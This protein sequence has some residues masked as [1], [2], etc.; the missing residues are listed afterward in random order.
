THS[1]TIELSG[2]VPSEV[3]VGADI[4]LK[5]K[6]SCPAGCDLRGMP[7]KVTAPDGVAV[8][9]EIATCDAGINE[10]ADVTLKAPQQVGEHVLSVVFAPHEA[11]GVLHEAKALPV[12]VRTRPHATSLAVWA[13]PSP[14]V[15]GERFGIKVGAKSAA[16]CKL[17]A[18]EIEVRDQT[19][20]IIA[21]ANLG[22]T[23]WPETSALFWTDVELLAP[24]EEGIFSWSVKFAAA[25]V[26]MPHEGASSNFSVVVVKP[27]QHRL[28]VNVIEKETAA[29]VENVQVRLG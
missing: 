28:T 20:A 25:E 26:E 22:E 15:M 16:G 1:T 18:K 7:V 2:A 17:D 10:T 29:P 9:S 14:V 12:S 24:A 13:V 8:A 21:R 4:I 5:V 6:V 23:P 19:G 27:P 11:D 3:A